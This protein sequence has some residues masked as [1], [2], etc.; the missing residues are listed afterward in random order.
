MVARYGGDE[1]VVILQET[2]ADNT[3]IVAEKL[4]A[5]LKAGLPAVAGLGASIGCATLQPDMS[6]ESLLVFADQDM[7]RQKPHHRG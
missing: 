1:F 5:A 3:G 2:N 4:R 6:A 7:Y